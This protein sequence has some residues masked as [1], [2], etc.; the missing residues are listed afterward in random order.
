L[1][2]H[3]FELKR[4]LEVVAFIEEESTRWGMSLMGSQGMLGT[5]A[6][7]DIFGR[8]DDNGVTIADAL[9]SLG[10]DPERYRDATRSPRDLDYYLEL[11]IEQGAVL[12]SLGMPLGVVTGIAAPIFMALTLEGKADHAGATPMH[13]R[14]DALIGAAELILAAR[15]IAEEASS[16]SVATVGRCEVTPGATNV[17]PGRVR[18]SF[19]VRDMDSDTR[20]GMLERLKGVVLEVA[21]KY[22]LRY[23][24]SELARGGPVVLPQHMIDTVARCLERLGLPV[25][26]LPSGA[27]HDAQVMA[28]I[29]DAAMIF[30][31]SR[32]GVS[33]SP[34]EFSAA[35][36]IT[37][38][39]K[40]LLQTV[41]AL[42]A[43]ERPTM[44]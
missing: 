6:H 27:S 42:D 23:E 10:L 21:G 35:E 15:R 41:L 22:S 19:D 12:D 17:I 29:A 28:Q 13:L 26:H 37:A 43:T 32:D 9:R 30:V 4:P 5:L 31:R 44:R 2:Q 40:V 20:E 8:K 1:S 34:G 25:F 16:T 11:H 18:M 3:S 39:A 33:H 38:G 36:D 7:D 24:M 14:K